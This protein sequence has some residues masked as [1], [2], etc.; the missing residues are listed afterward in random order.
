MAI[1]RIKLCATNL[2]QPHVTNYEDNLTYVE[3]LL[4]MFKKLNETIVQVN[5][6]T[7]DIQKIADYEARIQALEHAVAYDL[8]ELMDEKILALKNELLAEIEAKVIEI[9][10]YV[11]VKDA[12]LQQQIDNITIGRV[13][14]YDPT[15]GQYS[16]LQT[17]INNIY[18]AGLADALT[19]EEYDDLELTA[20]AYDAYQLTASEYDTKGKVLLV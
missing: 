9:R 20:T 1:N 19:A 10:S 7:E 13:N 5:K 3:F 11:D 2:F 14:L 8:P 6:N 16:P 4:G 18:G 15:T 17:V 12:Y